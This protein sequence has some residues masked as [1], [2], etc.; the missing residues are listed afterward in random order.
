M[1]KLD[2]VLEEKVTAGVG[3]VW[4]YLVERYFENHSSL[5][6]AILG[7][8][9]LTRGAIALGTRGKEIRRAFGK[10]TTAF[11]VT[12]FDRPVR[13]AIRNTSGPFDLE[14]EYRFTAEG[15]ITRVRLH[16]KMKPHGPMR[17]LFPW[18]RRT[19]EGQVR[20]NMARLPRVVVRG[21]E[22]TSQ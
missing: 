16:F 14:R 6:P 5:D 19:I 3:Q 10:R 1:S 22:A 9:R 12:A 17:L 18:I 11:K 2:I 13:F 15:P 20:T 8:K 21:I 4:H 7:M